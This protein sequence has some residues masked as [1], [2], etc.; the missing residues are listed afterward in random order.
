MFDLL[1]KGAFIVDGT[2]RKA[3]KSGLAV[4]DGKITLT[5]E[6]V[7][8][9]EVID[10][11]G[12]FVCPGFIDA[13]S[14]GDGVLGTP[15]GR[16]CKTSQGVTTEITG[17]CGATL[18]PVL[19]GR[20]GLLRQACGSIAKHLPAAMDTF[21]SLQAYLNY[22]Q[23][24][25]LTANFKILTGH[26]AL[27][28]ATVGFED[29]EATEKELEDMKSLLR[30]SMEQGS[31]GFSTGLIYPPSCFG[32]KR[33]IVELCKVVAEYGGVY[34]THM[35]NEASGVVQSVKDS[36]DVARES[37]CKLEISHHKVCGR[38]NW[39]ASEQTLK[40]MD[41]AAAQGVALGFDV[42][43]YTASCSN[44][45]VCLPP[46]C[47]ARGI[48]KMRQMVGASA[49][50]RA[51]ADE[52]KV[53]DG[54]YR[55]CGGFTGIMISGCPSAPEAEGK[56]VADYAAELGRDPFDVYFDLLAVNG[57]A[58]TAIYF[59]MCDEDLCRIVGHERAMIGSDGVVR[60]LVEKTHP[61]GF[62]AFPHCISTF[63]K[64]KKLLSLEAMIR[65]MTSLPASFL[66]LT[67]KGVIADGADADL[68]IFDYD[69]I[70][71]R[72]D[73]ASPLALCDGIERV[74]VAGETVY[75]DKELTGKYPGKFLKP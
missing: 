8:A 60:D 41:E 37:G 59:S 26:F 14:H 69:R 72:A 61:R 62:G 5:S 28:A 13:H 74:V 18:Y 38:D 10:A 56:T 4:S 35:R 21:T 7:P 57:S 64:E 53:M 52:M 49:N 11:S 46:R 67:G 43:P 12:L 54:R 3:F 42:Y 55:H 15:H 19:P 25:D 20:A 1:I 36:L 75:K 63:V 48:E 73:Y 66:N 45:N 68:L 34:A 70:C 16:L 71:D 24:L 29:R 50:R 65:K 2:G 58:A 30:Q 27:R 51:I 23:G 40:L 32:R 17:Q 39:G 47:F 6:D 9:R 44:L 31:L 22:V 33:E